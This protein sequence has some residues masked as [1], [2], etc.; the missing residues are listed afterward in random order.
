[1]NTNTV[2]IAR[3]V[4]VQAVESATKA[5]HESPEW[6][7]V[8]EAKANLERFDEVFGE[9]AETVPMT[10]G[11]GGGGTRRHSSKPN[12]AEQIAAAMRSQPEF[13]A[14]DV[15]A[16]LALTPSMTHYASTLLNSSPR[17]FEKVRHGK[18]RVISTSSGVEVQTASTADGGVQSSSD[19]G[20]GTVR[21]GPDH[22][23]NPL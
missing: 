13:S 5:L 9:D 21:V 1:M 23:E 14:A 7:A 4:F 17:L 18:F 2:E 15:R 16:K 8:N 3:E 11:G 6:A 12:L 20:S 19:V 10:S 22:E